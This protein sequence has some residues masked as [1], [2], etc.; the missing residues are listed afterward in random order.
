MSDSKSEL[1][2]GY[3]CTGCGHFNPFVPY[4]YGHW[5]DELIHACAGCEL[6][7]VVVAGSARPEAEAS[8]E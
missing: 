4:V 3:K 1:P 7:H 5:R 2:G 8:H 6:R